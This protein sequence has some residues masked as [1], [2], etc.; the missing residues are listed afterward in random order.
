MRRKYKKNVFCSSFSY[1]DSTQA[2]FPY[3]PVHDAGGL[4]L[5]PHQDIQRIICMGIDVSYSVSKS[6]RQSFIKSVKLTLLPQLFSYSVSKSFSMT[7]RLTL[8][9]HQNIQRIIYMGIDV[10]YSVSKSVSQSF[11]KSVRLTLLP[12]PTRINSA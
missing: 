9:S 5:L 1:L 11:N 10:S 12:Y 2:V 6:A 3:D 8:L 7:V 4:T